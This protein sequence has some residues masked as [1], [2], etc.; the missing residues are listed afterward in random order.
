[1]LDVEWPRVYGA[2]AVDN[3]DDGRA[4]KGRVGEE[5]ISGAKSA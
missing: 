1:M 4:E 2:D 5:Y 3:L